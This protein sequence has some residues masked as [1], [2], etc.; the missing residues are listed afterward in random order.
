MP[1][2]YQAQRQP[3]VP[4]AM[5]AMAATRTGLTQAMAWERALHGGRHAGPHR[6]RVG[7]GDQ[8]PVHGDGAGLGDAGEEP[9]PEQ[10]EGIDGE[11]RGKDEA[12]EQQGW[13]RRR[14]GTRLIRS[15]SHPMG[16]APRT[17]KAAEAVPMKTMAPSLM[18]N[19]CWISGAR[20][21]MA[22]PSSSSSETMAVRITNMNQPPTRRPWRSVIG[23]ALTPGRR[24]SGKTISS[25][26]LVLSSLT[27][28]L[29][30][31]HRRRPATPPNPAL[32]PRSV[33]GSPLPGTIVATA[34][35]RGCPRAASGLQIALRSERGVEL[36]QAERVVVVVL[37][38]VQ[39]VRTARRP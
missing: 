3:W 22:A 8:R 10:H 28:R 4:P 30:S 19:V 6:D 24:S 23:A 36:L 27:G 11:A 2:R 37:A 26:A 1:S 15:A 31:Q 16:T 35:T 13:R 14:S 25:R 12:A 7:V 34:T 17:K 29:F 21:L 18:W 5:S 9:G 33:P 39:R 20:T 32:R 38:R